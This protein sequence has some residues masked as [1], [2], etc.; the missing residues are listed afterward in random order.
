MW[1]PLTP[2]DPVMV[3]RAAPATTLI[4]APLDTF[5]AVFHRVS[6]ITHLLTEPAPEIVALLADAP[7][8][9][10]TLLILLGERYELADADPIALAARLDELIE[11]GLVEKTEAAGA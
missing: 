7:L 4:A 2:T 1:R 8:T 10:E 11:A 6:G 9:M 5:T 3:Y